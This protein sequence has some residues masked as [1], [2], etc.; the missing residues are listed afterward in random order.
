[1]RLQVFGRMKPDEPCLNIHEQTLR[2]P[3]LRLV[4]ALNPKP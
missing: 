4:V 3:S 1:M 2:F